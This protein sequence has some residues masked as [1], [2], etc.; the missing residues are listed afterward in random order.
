[1]SQSASQ[2]THLVTA[3]ATIGAGSL[4]WLTM[5]SSAITAMCVI[6]TTVTALIFGFWNARSNAITAHANEERNK[7]NRR[8]IIDELLKEI[9]QDEVMRCC[10]DDVKRML[11]K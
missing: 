3:G 4:E 10:V 8:C 11:R 7:I 2:T 1:M 5:N 9:E 6:L